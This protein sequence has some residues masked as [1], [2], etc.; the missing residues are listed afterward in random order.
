M[1]LS[2]A[3]IV[4]ILLHLVAV[5]GIYAFS[6]IKAHQN[7][8]AVASPSPVPQLAPPQQAVADSKPELVPVSNTTASKTQV[9]SKTADHK[10]TDPAGKQTARDSGQIYTVVKGDNP[11][12][13]AKRL[14]V[15]YDELLKLN[16]IEDPK[17]LQIGQKLR[18]PPKIQQTRANHT[19]ED[20]G[21]RARPASQG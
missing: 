13:I 17:K 3:L 5:G 21:S 14:G 9:Q 7:S 18:L 19:D 4:V 20:G 2:S 8:A 10:L 12:T 6:S 15:N 11:V 16:K 1:R